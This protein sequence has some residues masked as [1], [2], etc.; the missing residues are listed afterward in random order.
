MP[1]HGVTK[2]REGYGIKI[3]IFESSICL[4]FELHSDVP[5][6]CSGIVTSRKQYL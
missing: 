2:N 4:A 3:L 5:L 6:H 1:C